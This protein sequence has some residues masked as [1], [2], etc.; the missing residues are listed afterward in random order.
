MINFDF[1]F[2]QFTATITY[3]DSDYNNISG[4][5]EIDIEIKN[6]IPEIE[7]TN[8]PK[9]TYFINEEFNYSN[10]SIKFKYA[11][12]TTT[13]ITRQGLAITMKVF[14]FP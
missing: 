8:D 6:K 14:I 2:W 1:C 10:M 12:D 5:V 11:S 13:E 9:L 7:I 3:I 4:S